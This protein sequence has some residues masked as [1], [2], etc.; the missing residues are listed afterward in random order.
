[1]ITFANDDASDYGMPVHPVCELFPLLN[2]TELLRLAEDIKQHRQQ[3]PIVVHEGQLVDGRN[4]LLACRKAGVAP[5][6]QNWD[7][8]GSLT[9]F[10]WSLNGER[11]H[12]NS[13]QKAAIAVVLLPYLE[14]EAAERQ[15]TAGESG[16]KGG[17]GKKRTLT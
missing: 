4:R 16:K 12:L 15:A 10:A 11:R 2:P 5:R 3:V 17:R 14:Q 9:R 1:M 7:G 13:S 6:F 8:K